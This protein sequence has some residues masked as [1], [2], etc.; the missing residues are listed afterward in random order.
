MRDRADFIIIGGGIAGASVAYW[1]APHGRV[2]L[3]ERE[4]QPG[5]H[6]TG[7][8]AAMF[9]ESYGTPQ[10]RALTRASRSFFESAPEEFCEHPILT[11]RGALFVAEHQQERLLEEHWKTLRSFS[12]V[13]V[14]M[15]AAESCALMPVL[16][17][18]RVSGAVYDPDAA[19]MDVHALH[20]GYLRGMRRAGGT[21]MC[22]AEVTGLERTGQSW[23]VHAGRSEIEAPVVINAAGAWIDRVGSLA[24]LDPLGIEPRR[25]SALVF[26]SAIPAGFHA[27]P[28]SIGVAEDWYVKPYAGMLLGSSANADPVEPEDVQAEELDIALAIHRIEEVTSLTIPRPSR[29]WA[30]LRSFLPDGELVG[31][32]DPVS[33]GFFWLAGQGGYGIQTSAAMGEACA[34]L[35]RGRPIPQRIADFELTAAMLSPLRLSRQEVR[36]CE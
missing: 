34:W 20:Q 13:A 7:R 21:V 36:S 24:G 16:R 2:V 29:T 3:L 11:P 18:E 28:L 23:C 27:W 10:V 12:R 14:R 22:D 19:D 17:P 9:M 30:G 6:S 33:P 32:F 26:N 15:D 5:Y 25:R 35:A 8:S 1:L 31:G 4:G